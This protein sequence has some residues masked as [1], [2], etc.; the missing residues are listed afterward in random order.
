[1]FVL[2]FTNDGKVPHCRRLCSGLTLI[3]L[4]A[5]AKVGCEPIVLENTVFGKIGEIFVRT[6]QPAF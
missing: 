1:V 6:A 2:A 4:G 5:A 3:S